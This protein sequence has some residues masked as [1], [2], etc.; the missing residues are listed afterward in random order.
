V[1]RALVMVAAFAAAAR[2][3]AA[4]PELGT[5][6]ERQAGARLYEKNCAQC[7]GEKGDGKGVAAPFVLPKPRDF[8]SG[9]FKIRTTPSGSL[10]T[11]EDLARIIRVGMPYTAMPA[12]RDF[13]DAD[14]R[15]LVYY[16]KSL[17]PEFA[18]PGRQPKPIDVPSAPMSGKDSIEKGKK[19]YADLGCANCHGELGRGDG[20]SAP[21]LKDDWGNPI[22]PADLT[23]RWTFRGGPKKTDVFRAFSTGLNGTP[24]PS[25]F[26]SLDADARWDLVAYIESLGEDDEPDYAT[27]VIAKKIAKAIDPSDPKTFE[28][29]KTAYFPVVGQIMQ[30]VREFHPSANG[31]AVRAV[32]ND[33]DLALELR[34]HDMRADTTGKNAPDAKVPDEEDA[35]PDGAAPGGG[36]VWGEAEETAPAPS[37]GGGFWEEEGGGAKGGPSSEFSDAVAVQFPTELPMTIR[38]PY[39][40]FGDKERSV[41]LWFVDLAQK[42]PTLY[43]G[44]GSDALE[45][46]GPRALAVVSSYDHGEWT[47]VFKRKLRSRGEAS[48]EEGSFW[49]IAFSVWDGV[50]RERGSKRGLTNWWTLYLEPA[51]GPAPQTVMAKWAVGVFAVEI[52]V[53]AWARRRRRTGPA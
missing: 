13:S 20:P 41:D 25:F 37:G 53:I 9:K 39:F 29:A 36:S 8:T 11:D 6:A 2:V 16:V 48:F 46:R 50:E 3:A 33:D 15:N 12:W 28:D 51:G 40:L 4:A 19:I 10:P 34:W 17:S 49:P 52:V 23:K 42:K 30:K 47:V 18:N 32:Y 38:K 26:D 27:V 44:R 21:A 7:H 22:R 31:I 43:L 1:K 45:S 14:V 24:M 35:N 5:D